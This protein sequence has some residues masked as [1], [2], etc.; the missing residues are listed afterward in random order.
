[1]AHVGIPHF[2]IIELCSRNFETNVSILKAFEL[3]HSSMNSD[4]KSTLG[5]DHRDVC[6]SQVFII[7]RCCGDFETECKHFEYL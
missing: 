4:Q 2:F 3:N 5:H 7:E 1:M 6:A